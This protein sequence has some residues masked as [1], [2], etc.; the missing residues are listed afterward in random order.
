MNAARQAAGMFAGPQSRYSFNAGQYGK[1]AAD[2]IGQYAMQNVGIGNQAA[3]QNAAITNQQMQ[4]DA[5]RAKRLYDAGVIGEQQYQNAMRPAR[6]AV[7]QAYT[8]GKQNAA[9]F[10][11]LSS[12]QSPYYAYDPSRGTIYFRSEQARK[13]FYDSNKQDNSNN[14]YASA[15]DKAEKLADERNLSGK[16]R[17][18]FIKNYANSLMRSSSKRYS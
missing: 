6:A 7:L 3:Q 15:W 14:D 4:Y 1:N 5:Q 8:Q 18:E 16:Q 12:T 11:N 17:D 13:D 9:D 2:I 10:Y